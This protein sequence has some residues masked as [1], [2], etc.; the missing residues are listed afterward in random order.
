M[1][2]NIL[3]LSLIIPNL[4][5]NGKRIL[6][7]ILICIQNFYIGRN[8]F[9]FKSE[10]L[11]QAGCH[12]RLKLALRDPFPHDIK[13]RQLPGLDILS[14][15]KASCSSSSVSSPLGKPPPCIAADPILPGHPQPLGAP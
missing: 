13:W 9:H 3:P 11:T 10:L 4:Y 15:A 14:L 2:S 1:Y 5:S 12:S 8:D 7:K 6:T